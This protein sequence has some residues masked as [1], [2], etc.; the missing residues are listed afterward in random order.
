ML[1]FTLVI[2]VGTGLAFSL[3]PVLSSVRV[4][5]QAALKAV[6]RSTTAGPTRQRA[7]SMLVTGEVALSAVLLIVAS[8]LMQSLYRMHQ[9]RLGFTPQGLITFETPFASEGH[10]GD[11]DLASFVRTLSERIQSLPGVQSV[12]AIN[13]LPLDGQNNIPAQREGH[14]E[15][16]IGGMEYRMITPSYFETMGIP[17]RRG[18]LFTADDAGA[19]Q[20]VGF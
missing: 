19:A 4:D 15:Q 10:R 12:A 1:I 3:V 16:S 20:G 6:G 13:V 17:L 8:L 14:P 5:I 2:A 7:R 11:T 18:R 9:E